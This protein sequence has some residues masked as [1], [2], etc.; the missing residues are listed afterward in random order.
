MLVLDLN[1]A[2]EFFA[3]SSKDFDTATICGIWL[4]SVFIQLALR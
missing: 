3:C 1:Q 4:V 2:P